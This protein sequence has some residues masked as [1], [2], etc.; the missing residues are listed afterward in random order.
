MVVCLLD[1]LVVW[2]L[3]PIDL[4]GSSVHGRTRLPCVYVDFGYLALFRKVMGPSISAVVAP[5]ANLDER[6]KNNFFHFFWFLFCHGT[7]LAGGGLELDQ[8]H[9]LLG[10]R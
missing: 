1:G 8:S 9:L 2:G 7:L 10:Y 5:K 4:E 6:P 3:P